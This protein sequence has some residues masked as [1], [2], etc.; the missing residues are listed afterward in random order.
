[1]ILSFYNETLINVSIVILNNDI[2]EPIEYFTV[3]IFQFEGDIVF[4]I[5]ETVVAIIDDDGM[6]IHMYMTTTYTFFISMFLLFL[7]LTVG[8]HKE[9][10]PYKDCEVTV[11]IVTVSGVLQD[12]AIVYGGLVIGVDEGR[13][14]L[15][16]IASL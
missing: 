5:T 3:S 4:P 11:E 7:V 2:V 16:S 9:E 10:F 6:L 8:F 12:D 14:S 15:L 1:M 13:I